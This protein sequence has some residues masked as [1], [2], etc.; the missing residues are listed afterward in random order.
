MFLIGNVKKCA[1][2]C[3]KKVSR[4]VRANSR[5]GIASTLT[6]PTLPIVKVTAHYREGRKAPWEARWWVNR[7]MRTRFFETE[8]ERNLFIKNFSREIVQHGE[9]VYKFDKNRM[10]RAP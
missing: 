4:F 10:R 9:E 6:P 7:Q 5:D 2:L 1:R 3:E 8:D